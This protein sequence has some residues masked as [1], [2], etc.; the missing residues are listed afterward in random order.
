MAVS[1]RIT[2]DFEDEEQNLEKE[3]RLFMEFLDSVSHV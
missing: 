1:I 3:F 2:R